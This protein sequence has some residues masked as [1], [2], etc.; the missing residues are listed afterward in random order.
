MIKTLIISGGKLNKRFA[1]SIINNNTFDIIIAV[2]KG[3]EIAYKLDII[4][5]YIIG[6][7]DSVNKDI[8]QTYINN[9][10]VKI[11]KFDKEKDYTDTHLA[12]KLAIKLNSSQIII[13]G[14]YRYKSRPYNI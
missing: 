9:K 2:D 4:P 10:N 14:R 7:F 12:V 5:S 1:K 8:L 3:L 11:N 6:D 13:I